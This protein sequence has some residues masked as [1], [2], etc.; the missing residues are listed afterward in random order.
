ME[1][2]NRIKDEVKMKKIVVDAV[3]KTRKHSYV[4]F[5]L[6]GDTYLRS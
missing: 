1:P 5:T 2:T 6:E 3:G 4:V